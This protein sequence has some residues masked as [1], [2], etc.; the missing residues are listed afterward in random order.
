MSSLVDACALALGVVFE[1]SGVMKVVSGERWQVSGT[2]FATGNSA[3]DGLV[4]RFLPWVEVCLGLL[5]IVRVATVAAATV[6][7]ILLCAFTFAL[8]KVLV[9]GQRPPCMCFGATRSRPISWLS[10][11]RNIVLLACAVTTIVGA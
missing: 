1:W 8:V 5:L 2:P 7:L 9:R 4:R 10:V 3:L 11:A 6:A